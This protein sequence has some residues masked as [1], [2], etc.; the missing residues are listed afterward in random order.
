MRSFDIAIIGGGASGLAAAI[1]AKRTARNAS[2]A[3]IERLPKVGKKILATGNGRCNLSNADINERNYERHYHGTNRDLARITAGFSVPDF[4][5]GLGVLCEDDGYGRIYPHCRSAASVLDALRLECSKLGV[6]EICGFTVKDIRPGRSFIIS[7]DTERISA[8]SVIL[9]GG[10]KSQAALGS[11]GSLLEICDRLGVRIIKPCPA[12]VPL[13]TDPALVRPLKGQRAEAKV[14]FSVNDKFLECTR[15]E[16]QFTDGL[17][18]GICVFDL[19]YLCSLHEWQVN[20]CELF[21]DLLPDMDA[22]QVA[23]LIG[24][25]RKIRE[26][27]SAEDLL[28]G[29]FTRPMGVYLLKRAFGS[30]P[31]KAGKITDLETLVK[32]IKYLSFPVTGT[33]GFERSQVTMGGIAAPLIKQTNSSFELD[34]IPG[35]YACGEIID[36]SGDCGGFNLDFAFSSGA[37]AGK[38]AASDLYGR[39]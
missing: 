21:L 5:A 6:G 2:V 15:G 29:I 34:Y 14:Y 38:N 32:T 22:G 27:A 36:I 33:A 17:L 23:E 8:S 10:G 35:M 13:K 9:A 26:N 30:L 24:C 20:K 12:L 25:T 28:S 18:S 11:D 16:V 37:I 31:D 39:N 1:A 3:V 7:S 4:F 19:S